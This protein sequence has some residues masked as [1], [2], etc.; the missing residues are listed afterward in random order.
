MLEFILYSVA[1]ACMLF[2]SIS[3]I[4]KLE[5]PDFASYFM[6]ASGIGIRLIFSIL[7]NNFFTLLDGILGLGAFCLIG[8]IMYY[9]G[10]W[11]GGD[12]KIMMG[13]GALAGVG[14]KSIIQGEIPFP[15]VAF[16]CMLVSGAVIG[17]IYSTV[18]FFRNRKKVSREFSKSR[19]KRSSF[20]K[21]AILLSI[22]AL[23]IIFFS[24][25]FYPDWQL[26]A[27]MLSLP[28]AALGMFY[29]SIFLNAVQECC[30]NRL[31][32]P[33]K[34]TEGDWLAQDVVVA[35]R[36]VVKKS[37]TGLELPEL[38]RILSLQRK[39]RIKLIKV[40]Y[41]MPFVPSFFLGL[42]AAI[43]MRILS[44]RIFS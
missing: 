37:R 20:E 22:L 10:Q 18:L 43:I 5:V 34:L 41:G 32:S 2:S 28:I 14:L 33:E 9:A 44:I 1:L 4:K 17:V 21:A 39:G 38:K 11:G 31:I 16:F 19:Q 25:R 7:Q 15:A 29:L 30:M 24:S 6:I 36:V 40:K 23:V 12:A 13:F 26:R 42:L 27:M 3:D 8:I 35:G